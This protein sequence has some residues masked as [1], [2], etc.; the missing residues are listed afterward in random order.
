M[1]L[2]SN[3]SK[4]KTSEWLEVPSWL[5]GVPEDIAQQVMANL[6]DPALSPEEQIAPLNDWQMSGLTGLAEYG[7]GRGGQIAD[8]QYQAGTD[9]LGYGQQNLD[10]FTNTGPAQNE[11]IDM[12]QISQYIDNDILQGQIDAA[13]RDGYRHLTEGELPIA[14]LSMAASG[15]TGGSKGDIGQALLESR[16]Y[17]RAADVGG[18]MRGDAY[19][20]AL[21][22]GADQASQNAQLQNQYTLAS[23]TVGLGATK[24][25]SDM[26]STAYNTDL[27]NQ[28]NKLRAGGVLQDQEQAVLDRIRLDPYERLEFTSG[29]M[30]EQATTYGT[31]KTKSKTTEKTGL[32]NVAVGLAGT[33]GG[34]WLSGQGMRKPT[35]EPDPVPGEGTTASFLPGGGGGG[36][37]DMFGGQGGGMFGGGGGGMDFGSSGSNWFEGALSG[38]SQGASVGGP[39]GAVAGGIFGAFQGE[40]NKKKADQAKQRE[41]E[42]YAMQMQFWEQLLASLGSNSGTEDVG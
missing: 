7:D 16:Y 28:E 11:G 33:L 40:K 15:G 34:A 23:G 38:G 30:N 13:T 17:D 36:M 32:G 4:T 37:M 21:G 9:T 19:S 3:T 18:A 35:G 2:F 26:L 10:Y 41:Q 25:G 24:L 12:D 14:R 6:N 22:I 8:Q 39:W 1:G 20:Q 27:N 31:H 29:L 42:L 5:E